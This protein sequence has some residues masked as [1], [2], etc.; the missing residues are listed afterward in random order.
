MML[1]KRLKQLLS[2]KGIFKI[3]LI[4][5]QDK[6]SLSMSK[7]FKS[8]LWTSFGAIGSLFFVCPLVIALLKYDRL[9]HSESLAEVIIYTYKHFLWEIDLDK[10]LLVL[11]FLTG[12]GLVGYLYYYLKTSLNK[13][14]KRLS[15]EELLVNG[16]SKTLE[17][18]SS[19]RWDYRQNI[20]NKEIEFA[21]LKTIAA[22]MN[23]T[24]GTLLIGV[25]DNGD[26]LGL[27]KDYQSLKKKNRD[28]FEQHIIGLVALN[29]GTYCCKNI[30]VKFYE[31]EGKDACAI[32][33]NSIKTPV[34][35]KYQQAVSFFVRT[36]NHTRELDIEA[37]MKYINN[38][39]IKNL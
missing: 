19:L 8:F 4:K 30:L 29:I 2:H 39:K 27:E 32:E 33:V 20:T 16:E 28:G 6:Y 1:Q 24:G 18:K 36:G 35:L 12:G 26:P 21:A 7:Q 37:S 3:S 34:F 17:F 10:V 14:E 31:K 9:N 5:I 13:R 22:F 23:T 38:R 25:A 11:I 15:L